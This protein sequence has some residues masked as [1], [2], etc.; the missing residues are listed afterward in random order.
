MKYLKA[1]IPAVSRFHLSKML[2]PTYSEKVLEK[3]SLCE[4]EFSTG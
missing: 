4:V 3:N 2:H 1:I